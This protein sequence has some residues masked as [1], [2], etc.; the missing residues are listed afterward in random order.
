MKSLKNCG[1]L[2][3]MLA[4]LLQGCGSNPG[5]WPPSSRPA[6]PELPSS[7]RQGPKQP[8]CSPT[9]LE[10]W[11]QKVEQWQKRLTDPAAQGLP[12]SGFMM[13]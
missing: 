11:S 12:A 7:A 6:M 13:E 2:L 5:A 8:Q 10:R 9:C 4:L 1:V 3:L